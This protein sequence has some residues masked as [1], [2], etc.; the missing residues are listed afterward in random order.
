MTQGEIQQM[1]TDSLYTATNLYDLGLHADV[2]AAC[3]NAEAQYRTTKL[4][5]LLVHQASNRCFS[6]SIEEFAPNSYAGVLTDDPASRDFGMAEIR[7]DAKLLWKLENA[8]HIPS[9]RELL[10]DVTRDL[11][12]VPVRLTLHCFQESQFSFECAAA[13]RIDD[14]T[15]GTCNH[16]VEDTQTLNTYENACAKS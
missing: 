14:A 13:L 8:Q 4:V 10:D 16:L 11:F 5:D 7:R 9:I 3:S 1:V 6:K 15:W 12:D 2:T